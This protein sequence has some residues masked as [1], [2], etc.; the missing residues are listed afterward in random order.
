MIIIISQVLEAAL[1]WVSYDRPARA[2]DLPVVLSQV[3][4]PL[5]KDVKMLRS[6]LRDS[7]VAAS[8]KCVHMLNEAIR[9]H[10]LEYAEKLAYWRQK[11]E[12]TGKRL[13]QKPSRYVCNEQCSDN[14]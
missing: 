3:Q 6:T 2:K 12:T 13:R 5:I 14:S 10:Q 1:E 7:H 4:W 8:T 11:D 9:Y